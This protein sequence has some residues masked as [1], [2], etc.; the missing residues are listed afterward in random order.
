MI[1]FN[2]SWL[3]S[4]RRLSYVFSHCGAR[5]SVGFLVGSFLRFY[6]LIVGKGLQICL[7]RLKTPNEHT[8]GWYAFCVVHKKVDVN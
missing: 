7:K 4:Q 3:L 2:H 5:A 6:R 8:L 1:C